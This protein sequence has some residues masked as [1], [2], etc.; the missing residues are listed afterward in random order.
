MVIDMFNNKQLCFYIRNCRTG[1]QNGGQVP[2]GSQFF[3]DRFEDVFGIGVLRCIGGFGRVGGSRV[4][5]IFSNL[6]ERVG[7]WDNCFRGEE[8][9]CKSVEERV[10]CDRIRVLRDSVRGVERRV[11]G[12]IIGLQVGGPAFVVGYGIFFKMTVRTEA[13]YF[14]VVGVYG[15]L[16]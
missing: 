4:V 9:A 11:F 10:S 13:L 14:G 6:W 3:R 2:Y 16:T 1:L 7:G 15:N 12:G 5:R 8:E